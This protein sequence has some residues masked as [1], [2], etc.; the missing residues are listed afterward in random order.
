M[1][2]RF[3]WSPAYYSKYAREAIAIIASLND[4]AWTLRLE[5][6]NARRH[7]IT[8]VGTAQLNGNGNLI[9]DGDSDVLDT[10]KAVGFDSRDFTIELDFTPNDIDSDDGL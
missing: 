7:L 5:G 3:R 1:I 4:Y 9:L 6:E 2:R 10:D 8:A